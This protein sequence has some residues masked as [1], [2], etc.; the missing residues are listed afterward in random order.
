MLVRTN[1]NLLI[2]QSDNS[3]DYRWY[4]NIHFAYFIIMATKLEKM[5]VFSMG[6][7][8]RTQNHY[9]YYL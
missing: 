7:R 6:A 9:E 2:K 3:S 8:L 1:N 4:I 5:L